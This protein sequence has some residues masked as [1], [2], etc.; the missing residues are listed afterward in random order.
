M[1][2]TLARLCGHNEIRQ[3]AFWL[4]DIATSASAAD[5]SSSACKRAAASRENGS[6]ISGGIGKKSIHSS[7]FHTYGAQPSCF[8]PRLLA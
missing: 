6:S 4:N 5:N 7:P 3:H 2:V 8:K 1:T